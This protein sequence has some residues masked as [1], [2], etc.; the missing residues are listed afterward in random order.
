[1]MVVYEVSQAK[2]GGLDMT[3]TWLGLDAGIPGRGQG[4][5]EMHKE[6]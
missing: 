2:G 5:P 1:M 4:L 6:G 3:T